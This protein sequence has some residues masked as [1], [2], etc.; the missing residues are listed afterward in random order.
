MARRKAND[1]EFVIE[2]DD[3]VADDE[4]EVSSSSKK[5]SIKGGNVERYEVSIGPPM[6]SGRKVKPLRSPEEKP[7]SGKQPSVSQQA[8]PR[9][10]QGSITSSISMAGAQ[11]VYKIE[12]DLRRTRDIVEDLKHSMGMM[13]GDVKDLKAEMDRTSYL[14]RSLEGLKNAMKDIE[15]TVSELSGLYDLISANINPFVD[16]P[17]LQSRDQMEELKEEEEEELEETNLFRDITD[18][19]DE[20]EEEAQAVEDEWDGPNL[21]SEEW[22]LRWT[23]FLIVRVGKEGLERTLDYYMDLE[24]IDEDMIE[25]VLDI[26]RGTIGPKLPAEG[27]RSKWKLEAEDHVQSLEFI[28]NIRSKGR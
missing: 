16:I 20:E 1:V 28:K 9:Y 24:W 19:F 4:L 8:D 7:P 15:S 27:K 6:V 18:I 3:G 11:Q 26:A 13:E 22:I 10:G 14:L 12:D 17:P 21:E 2:E 23:K 5:G 25:K